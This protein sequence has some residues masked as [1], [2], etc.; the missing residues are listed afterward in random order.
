MAGFDPSVISEIGGSGPDLAAA[1]GKALTLSDL[2]DK[3]KLNKID[4]QNAE[5]Q[6]SDMTYARQI[7]SGADLS[8]LKGQNAAVAQITK[9]SPELGM[10]L[11]SSFQQ[12]QEKK[13]QNEI[14]QL[15]LYDKKNDIIGGQLYQLKTQHD[16][17]A[18]QGMNEQQIHDAMKDNV[19]G[20]VKGLNGQTLPDGSPL[21]NEQDRA[22]LKQG[23]AN[24]YS[25]P[26]IDSQV[27]RS[28]QARDALNQKLEAARAES[29]GDKQD[30][31]KGD[32]KKMPGTDASKYYRVVVGADGKIKS[33]VGEAPPPAS[34]VNIERAK[35]GTLDDDDAKFMAQ[36]YL[37]GDKSIFSNMGRGAQG[38]ANIIRVRKAIKTEAAAQGLSPSDVA[39][40]LAEFQGYVSEQRT[41]GTQ[42]ANVEMA[43]SEAKQ[44]ITNARGASDDTAISRAHVLGWNKIE[45]W[46][47]KELQDPKLASLKAAT[48]AVIN[49][50]SR[51]I[52]PKGVATQSDK[53]HGY[54]LLN[55][56]QDSA[57]YNAVLDRFEQEADASLAA[58]ES[59]RQ[60]LHDA[61]IGDKKTPEPGGPSAP[62][63]LKTTKSPAG[64]KVMK[65]D[66]QGNPAP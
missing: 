20:F 49:T 14:T 37:A 52:N 21:L 53:D 6:Q 45:Q 44:M 66:A 12:G 17:L 56:A 7:L 19:I 43:S 48:T 24:G 30:T 3:N 1:Q 47:Q 39:G 27:V 33:V 9:R 15:E 57:T 38:S 36:Q 46:G 26:F 29:A 5:Q 28:K 58:P 25:V 55:A 41:L 31:I 23:L 51:A 34:A 22:L 32:P 60:R 64:P 11:M 18:A 2:Y 35:E 8:D 61:F 63:P 65:F 62:V 54:E 59:A 50:W 40:R 16:A 4:V 13:A 42:Q 10:K